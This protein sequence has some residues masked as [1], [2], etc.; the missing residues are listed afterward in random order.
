MD[1]GLVGKPNVGKSTV[2]NAL[3]LLN[4][5]VAPYPFTTVEP[6]R[7]QSYVRFPCP[8]QELGQPCEPRNATCDSGVRLVP[9]QIVDVAGLVPGAHEGRGLGNKFLDDLRSADGFLHIVDASGG[10]DAEGVLTERHARDPREDVRFLQDELALWV[11]DIL[12]RQWERLAKT[13]ELQGGKI[14]DLIAERLTGLGIDRVRILQALRQFPGDLTRPSRWTPQDRTAL[15]RELL[16]VS[17]PSLVV[18][19]KVD[20]ADMGRVRDLL[21]DPSL[22]PIQPASAEMEL[23]LRR[24]AKA[25]LV[26]YRPGEGQF[27]LVDPGR[28][29]AAQR[30]ALD[31]VAG[32]LRRWGTTGVQEALERLVF[33]GLQR[34][35]VFPVEDETRWTDGQGH[36]LPDALL[37]PEGTTTRQ[38]AYLVHSDLGDNFIRALDGR[39]H[40]ALGADQPVTAGQVI[41]IVSRR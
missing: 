23:T 14:E 2:F 25:G 7:G 3:T 32:F 9:V 20:Q 24:A 8:H 17:K 12:G 33:E 41:R 34:R 16:R 26:D 35:V 6:N 28:L 11:S 4:A 38:V 5:P 18:A 1:I 29:S 15:A 30:R 19:N 21:A 27:R 37:V 31:S 36:V 10:T 40:R 39:T 22:H 13:L